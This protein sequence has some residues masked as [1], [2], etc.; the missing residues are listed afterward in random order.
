MRALIAAVFLLGACER[1]TEAKCKQQ[2]QNAAGYV[3]HPGSWATAWCE[4]YSLSGMEECA[5]MCKS[6]GLRFKSF[7]PGI[8]AFSDKKCE[9]QP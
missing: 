9:C 5:F 7:S 2:C 3:F 1:P 4:C 6:Q 8:A